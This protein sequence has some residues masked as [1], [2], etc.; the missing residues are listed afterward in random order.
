MRIFIFK[1]EA[2][3][4][5]RAF[6]GDLD[7]S[8]LPAQFRPWRAIGSIAADGDPP[9]QLPRAQIEKAINDQG[10]QLWRMKVGRKTTR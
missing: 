9:H 10:F 3:A 2:D 7:G 5:L 6:A 1:S 8:K 4:R